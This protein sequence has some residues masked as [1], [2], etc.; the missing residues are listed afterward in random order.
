M[1]FDEIFQDDKT[2]PDTAEITING[3]QI[4]LGAI[5]DRSRKDQKKLAAELEAVAKDRQ[6]VTELATQAA[7][8]H[9]KLQTQLEAA[10][11]SVAR[12]APSDDWE[13][14]PL[15]T[16]VVKKFKSIEETI[17]SLNDTNVQLA[18]AV[19]NAATIWYEDR[20]QGQ[21]ERGADRLKKS[22]KHK[23][24]SYEQVRDYA[25]KNN[26]LDGHKLPDVGK[27][28]LELTKEDDLERIRREAFEAGEKAGA[29]RGRMSSMTRPTSAEGIVRQPADASVAKHGLEGLG[30]DVAK[31][32]DLMQMLSELGAVDPTD[33]VQ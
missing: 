26:I 1:D 20:A 3:K 27:A 4:T 30:D 10:S 33:L 18:N 29:T 7:D 25:A 15:Y 22:A 5:R 24:M 6:G 8:L 23:D 11:S 12:V 21:F 16:P 32:P 9:R 14:D 28:I 31:D 19:K 2:Y 13:N 17:K